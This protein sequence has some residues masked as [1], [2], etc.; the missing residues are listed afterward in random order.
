M[1]NKIHF[2][3]SHTVSLPS[4]AFRYVMA[5]RM[6]LSHNRG[7]PHFLC[8]RKELDTL[9]RESSFRQHKKHRIALRRRRRC[10]WRSPPQ[11]ENPAAQD[12]LE[13][14]LILFS[15]SFFSPPPPRLRVSLSGDVVSPHLAYGI[16]AHPCSSPAGP[17]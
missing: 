1:N 9:M 12:S 10:C 6:R 8:W 4:A 17:K 7:Q 16:G 5:L 3:K 11:A 2:A 14:F 15:F 13:I